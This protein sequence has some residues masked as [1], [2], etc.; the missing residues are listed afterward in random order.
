M[1]CLIHKGK[2]CPR[3]LEYSAAYHCNLA[4][5]Q[6]SHLS[7]YT[8]PRFPEPDSLRADLARLEPVLHTPEFRL[9]GGEPLLNPD[10][11]LLAQIVRDS[12]IA[13]TI[14]ITTHGV[15]LHRMDHEL[16]E[17]IDTLRVTIY[18]GAAPSATTMA[19]T[20][21][22]ARATNTTLCVTRRPSFRSF[23][24]PDPQP[25]DWTARLLFRACQTAHVRQC[26]MLSDGRLFLCA[27]PL[28]L[29]QFL[30]RLGVQDYDSAADGFDIHGVDD[31]VGGLNAYLNSPRPLECCRYCLGDAGIWTEHRQL[32]R[33]E[34]ENPSLLPVARGTHLSP[35]RLLRNLAVRTY[36]DLRHAV[37]CSHS[38]LR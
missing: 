21:A 18:P 20:L 33:A 30:F 25:D 28:G 1:S 36:G 22:R 19:T 15:R 13:D 12:G 9:L 14:A 29:K 31:L 38:W 27:V 16:W 11:T 34:L 17:Q 6:C 35:V 32:K 37:G 8:A 2:L 10:L 23:T 26:H 7:P 4:C 5:N 3:T 24:L